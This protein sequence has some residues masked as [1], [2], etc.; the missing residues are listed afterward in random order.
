MGVKINKKMAKQ[1][2]DT[3]KDVCGHDINFINENGIIYASTN[4]ARIGD[5]HE[6]GFE[7]AKTNT[8]IEVAEDNS[9]EGT[10]KGVNIPVFHNGAL[11]S[12]IG[13]TGEPE[14]VRQ[15]AYLAVRITKLL[16]RE[17]ELEAF[18]RSQKEKNDFIVRTLLKGEI[19]DRQY[20]GEC[21]EELKISEKDIFKVIAIKLNTRHQE[22]NISLMEQKLYSLFHGIQALLYSYNYPNEYVL[23]IYDKNTAS[24]VHALEKFV[25]SNKGLIQIGIGTSQGLYHLA[26]SYEASEIAVKSMKALEEGL[27]IFENLDLEIIIGSLDKGIKEKYINKTLECLS[28]E[29][30]EILRVYYEEDMSLAATGKRLFLHKN[31]LQYKLDRIGKLS[32]YNPRNF[33]DAV[34]LYI[35]TK[36]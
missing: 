19:T 25:T 33:K 3:V 36:M 14:K 15:Y 32:G 27:A 9:F 31:T 2:V 18:N 21:L 5:F 23:I 26:E 24:T 20:L 28:D 13:I 35:A 10:Q 6:I 7:V 12:V 4:E 34:V 17:Q 22:M 16:I 30:K 8:T 11:L 29:D 1:I